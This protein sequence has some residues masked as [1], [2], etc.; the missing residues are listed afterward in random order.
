MTAQEPDPFFERLKEAFSN[1]RRSMR[2]GLEE[3]WTE[4]DRLLMVAAGGLINL[5]VL[6]LAVSASPQAS[7]I[8]REAG[9][10][11]FYLIMGVMILVQYVLFAGLIHFAGRLSGGVA[12]AADCRSVAAWW[13]FVSA[14]LAL[15]G[16]LPI[17]FLGL[18][19]LFGSIALL[20]AYVTEA[21]GYKSVGATMS[22]I[23]TAAMALMMLMFSLMAGAP[24]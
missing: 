1:P 6:R 22:V 15:L 14:P 16:L 2:R 5:I 9:V 7:E 20:A 8:L 3:R 24:G 13:M 11:G 18:V 23:S 19:A 17:P 4:S 12:S 10:F 21:Q